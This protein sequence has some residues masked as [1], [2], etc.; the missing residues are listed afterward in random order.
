M[1]QEEFYLANQVDG[2]LSDAQTMQMLGLPEGDSGQPQSSVPDA[3]ATPL[4]ATE[5]DVKTV[6]PVAT[7]VIVAK[8]GVHTIPYEKL[9]EARE[10][11][12]HWKRV[13]SETQQQLE[14][15]TKTPVAAAAPATTPT[16]ETS[17]VEDGDVFG[18]YSEE[19]I[20]SGVGKL[21]A[22]QTTAIKAEFEAKFN[23]LME[24]IQK[25]QADRE[26]DEHFS[27]INSKHPDVE[28]VVPSQ[29]FNN[30]IDAQPS[31]VRGSLKAAI[32][33]GTAAEVIEVLDAYKSATGKLPVVPGKPDAAVA[34]QAAIA[35]AQSAPPMSLS[36][37]PAGSSA[38]VDEAAAML[39]KSSTG[40]MDMFDGKTPEQIMAL[41]NKVL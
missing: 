1:N 13:A 34:A 31:V 19:A 21:V 8:D 41:M 32:D 14:A 9:T 26:T 20:K 27:A 36:E 23:A 11:E 15:L 40:M 6:E 29:E 16:V 39:E 17:A 4:P 35:K 10:A 37:I 3:D 25:K 30:W 5:V 22:S 2:E 24:P 38:V 12:Q 18:D 7:P 33:Q 28:S